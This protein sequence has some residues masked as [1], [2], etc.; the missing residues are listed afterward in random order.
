MLGAT[1]QPWAK[2]Q[3]SPPYEG[4]DK[5][6]VGIHTLQ[7]ASQPPL[8]P[9]LHKE[10]KIPQITAKNTPFYLEPKFFEKK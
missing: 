6:G 5:E 2:N 1:R 10:G 9:F 7:V 8:D 4:G 3:N